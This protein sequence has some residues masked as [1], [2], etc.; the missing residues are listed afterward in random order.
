MNKEAIDWLERPSST[1]QN[2]PT[3]AWTH[4]STNAERARFQ[5]ILRGMK[6]LK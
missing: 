2:M 1:H 3:S 4:L 6:L 5:D